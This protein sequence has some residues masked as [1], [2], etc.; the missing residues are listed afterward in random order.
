MDKDRMVNSRV[1]EE[2]QLDFPI[3]RTLGSLYF[4]FQLRLYDSALC[5]ANGAYVNAVFSREY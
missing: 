2:S 3:I 5:R 1:P 4:I